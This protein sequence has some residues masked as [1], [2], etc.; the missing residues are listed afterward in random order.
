M[1]W[2]GIKIP[3][4]LMALVVGLA[5]FWGSQWLYDRYNYERP[6]A[7]LLGENKDVVSYK[8]NDR[9]PVLEVEVKL[10]KVDNLQQ[11]YS[12]LHKSLQEIVGRRS[13]R[14]VLQDQR[15][16]T[17]NGIYYHTRLA[18]FEAMERGNF[19][20]MESYISRLAGREGSRARVW[21]DQE[22]LYIQVEHGGSYLYEIIPRTRVTGGVYP[23]GGE[24]RNPS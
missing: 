9:G 18:A 20:E 6:L 23:E 10:G 11:A 19:L 24:R 5:A 13:F 15:D 22:R 16:D 17:L 8:I 7:K 14:I 3:V 1:Q 2:N 12:G 21:L 4:V